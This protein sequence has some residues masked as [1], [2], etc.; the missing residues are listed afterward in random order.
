[1]VGPHTVLAGCTRDAIHHTSRNQSTRVDDI[2][3]I[4]PWPPTPGSGRGG[5]L[6]DH[7]GE[8]SPLNWWRHKA[9]RGK[10]RGVLGGAGN[11]STIPP[12]GGDQARTRR[13]RCHNN[14]AGICFRTNRQVGSSLA[15]LN[16]RNP[17][18]ILVPGPR[19]VIHS[20]QGQSIRRDFLTGSAFWRPGP[21]SEEESLP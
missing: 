5:A 16:W 19:S 8:A 15:G 1:M 9:F 21:S 3:S 20:F 10:S 13:R 6:G 14:M 4:R 12:P 17:T 2:R 11:D 18:I 7:T